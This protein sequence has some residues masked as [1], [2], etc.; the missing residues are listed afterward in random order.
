MDL[1]LVLVTCVPL[2]CF[3]LF[4]TLATFHHLPQASPI[5]PFHSFS[6]YMKLHA[7][8]HGS[9]A[10]VTRPPPLQPVQL[11]PHRRRPL[12]T[13]YPTRPL[14]ELDG[15]GIVGDTRGEFSPRRPGSTEAV[16]HAPVKAAA[17]GSVLRRRR[18][19]RSCWLPSRMST[20]EHGGEHSAVGHVRGDAGGWQL[21]PTP[22]TSGDVSL[23]SAFSVIVFLR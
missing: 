21:G 2:C 16:P 22:R 5:Q 1:L 9:H 12:K 19:G 14:Q 10:K 13:L 11:F 20:L 8:V 23:A 3:P 15:C 18:H 17:A 6:A 4:S 7:C